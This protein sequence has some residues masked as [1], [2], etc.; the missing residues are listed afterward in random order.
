MDPSQHLRLRRLAPARVA[1]SGKNMRHDVPGELQ[2]DTC[3]L[4]TTVREAA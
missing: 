3:E 4:V 1:I 2:A